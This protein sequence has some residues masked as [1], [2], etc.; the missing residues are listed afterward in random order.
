MVGASSSSSSIPAAAFVALIVSIALA[1]SIGPVA[2]Q[3]YTG[4]PI[5]LYDDPF[6]IWSAGQNSYCTASGS[7]ITCLGVT[8]IA[9]ATPFAVGG[10]CGGVP[11][12][13]GFLTSLYVWN[14][15]QGNTWCYTY[16]TLAQDPSQN[17][18]CNAAKGAD[19]LQ[20]QLRNWDPASDGSRN[21]RREENSACGSSANGWTLIQPFNPQASTMRPTSIASSGHAASASRGRGAALTACTPGCGFRPR[22]WLARPGAAPSATAAR[23]CSSSARCGRMR[24]AAAARHPRRPGCRSRRAR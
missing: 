11:Y 8:N 16:P 24:R 18:W 10:G 6:A 21:Q 4:N 3:T 19:A 13:Q 15:V 22:S 9:Q 7:K 1:A 5:L 23:R 2:A 20:F 14:Q 12:S 17:L